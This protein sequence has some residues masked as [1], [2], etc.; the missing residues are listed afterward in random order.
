M[1][2]MESVDGNRGVLV[3]D[4][5]EGDMNRMNGEDIGRVCVLKDGGGEDKVKV[6]S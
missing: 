3:V 5:M 6:V 1:G 2:G 4:G